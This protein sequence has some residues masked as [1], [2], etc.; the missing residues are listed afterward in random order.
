MR[1][2]VGRGGAL[3]LGS[4]LSIDKPDSVTERPDE[5]AARPQRKTSD[6]LRHRPRAVG[7]TRGIEAVKRRC[8][9]V[10]P[11]QRLLVDRPY[12]TLAQAGLDVEHAP[13]TGFH[14]R[15]SIGKSAVPRNRDA[16]RTR[17]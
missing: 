11:I 9:D 17:K 2:V 5:S 4:P 13:K 7:A 3:A 1:G 12:R 15:D 10:D 14:E 16:H 6:R 8:V